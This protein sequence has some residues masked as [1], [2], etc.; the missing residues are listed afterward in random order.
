MNEVSLC[1]EMC[2]FQTPFSSVCA[3]TKTGL[4][5]QWM[6]VTYSCK[7]K[8][9]WFWLKTDSLYLSFNPSK[10]SDLTHKYSMKPKHSFCVIIFLFD[11][12]SN[13]NSTANGSGCKVL[14]SEH[15]NHFSLILY[16]H[17]Q[18][19]VTS[20]IVVMLWMVILKES[21]LKKEAKRYFESDCREQEEMQGAVQKPTEALMKWGKEDKLKWLLSAD[22]EG[23]EREAADGKSWEKSWI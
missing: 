10:L 14:P 8:K 18:D 13:S 6:K 4:S 2:I 7:K 12:P 23:C 1:R 5:Y 21:G 3:K 22:W 19:H 9:G 16:S 11:G 20:S 15:Q 17:S